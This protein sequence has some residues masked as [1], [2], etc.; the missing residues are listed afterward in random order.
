MVKFF[1]RVSG[2]LGVTALAL[3]FLALVPFLSA[4]P[5]AGADYVPSTSGFSVNREFKSDRLPIHAALNASAWRTEFAAQV[6]ARAPRD[7]P[8][9]CDRSFSPMSS[10]RLAYVY[11]RCLS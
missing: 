9:A 11:G 1:V 3:C 5:T 7:I 6:A 4:A 10:P 8:F 2:A